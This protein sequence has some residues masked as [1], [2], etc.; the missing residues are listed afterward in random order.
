M[1]DDSMEQAKQLIRASGDFESES[2]LRSASVALWDDLQQVQEQGGLFALDLDGEIRYPRYAFLDD[3]RR[4][5]I[6]GFAA[7]LRQL[8]DK[9]AWQKAFWFESPN[10]YL[11]GQ[12]QKS[13]LRLRSAD[14]LRADRFESEGVQDG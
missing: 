5:I 4:G 9:D 8:R 10:G 2:S 12:S 7:T 6:P 11:S 1:T 3:P 13:Q 14:V